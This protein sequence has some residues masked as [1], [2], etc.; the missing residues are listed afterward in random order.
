MTYTFTEDEIKIFLGWAVYA[1]G[2]ITINNNNE[3]IAL[4]E[5]AT[6]NTEMTFFEIVDNAELRVY[7]KDKDKRGIR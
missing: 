4:C 3:L 6:A 1:E 7:K 2:E 5:K